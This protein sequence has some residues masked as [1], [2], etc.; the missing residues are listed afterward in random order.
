VSG[1]QHALAALYP[2]GKTWYSCYRRLGG[3]LGRSGWAQI[4]CPS[5]FDPGPSTSTVQRPKPE[6]GRW[7][8]DNNT[9]IYA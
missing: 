7:T 5:G 6:L 4:S 3:P 2:P 9:Y 8:A 1:Q